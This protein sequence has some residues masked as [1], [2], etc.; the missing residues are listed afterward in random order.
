M[1]SRIFRKEVLA[2]GV[3]VAAAATLGLPFVWR[4][5]MVKIEPLGNLSAKIMRYEL[6]IGKVSARRYFDLKLDDGRTLRVVA[7]QWDSVLVPG[8]TACVRLHREGTLLPGFQV[9][10][11]R[12]S[13]PDR[14]FSSGAACAAS[15]WGRRRGHTPAWLRWRLGLA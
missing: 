2:W 13:R 10:Q 8:D 12:A 1:P 3:A 5:T 14:R 6:V 4:G 11:D 15:L 7:G 9:L